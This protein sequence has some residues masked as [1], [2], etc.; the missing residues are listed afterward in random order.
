MEVLFG[1]RPRCSRGT[2]RQVRV[3]SFQRA[4]SFGLLTNDK[5]LNIA[6]S[7]RGHVCLQLVW[8]PSHLLVLIVILVAG[9]GA[10]SCSPP[11]SQ[12]ARL[13]SSHQEPK[14]EVHHSS[15][16]T[17][18]YRKLVRRQHGRLKHH[19]LEASLLACTDLLFATN[20]SGGRESKSLFPYINLD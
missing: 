6:Q 8:P 15:P 12:P 11:A 16:T 4:V 10:S 13:T 14:S 5:L 19:R 7:P 1:R 18:L 3:C 20:T 2:A 17:I 9:G